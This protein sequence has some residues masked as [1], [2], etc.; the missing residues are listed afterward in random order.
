MG[1]NR[2]LV[3]YTIS[4]IL[5][6]AL[7]VISCGHWN[8]WLMFVGLPLG[9]AFG[10]GGECR[11]LDGRLSTTLGQVSRASV[12][13]LPFVGSSGAWLVELGVPHGSVLTIIPGVAM[14]V[15]QLCA[16]IYVVTRTQKLAAE[17]L[18]RHC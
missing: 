11:Q 15:V 7:D 16:I 12:Y 5:A 4:V 17:T 18:P 9:F 6:S 2:R 14:L 8:R 3:L 13:V 1:L 10:V